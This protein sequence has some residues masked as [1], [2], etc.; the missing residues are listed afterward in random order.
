VTHKTKP[1]CEKRDTNQ[2]QC[3]ITRSHGSVRVL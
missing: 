3:T 1:A 2:R